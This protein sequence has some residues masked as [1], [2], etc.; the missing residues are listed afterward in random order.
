MWKL[1]VTAMLPAW[2]EKNPHCVFLKIFCIRVAQ[3]KTLNLGSF[4]RFEP[5]KD[6]H[7]R[8]SGG[9][10]VGQTPHRMLIN[11]SRVM[12]FPVRSSSSSSSSS[13]PSEGRIKDSGVGCL[14]QKVIA[15]SQRGPAC[16][17]I[18]YQRE[19]GN[20]GLRLSKCVACVKENVLW[21]MIES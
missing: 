7:I 17:H 6:E 8:T 16:L 3:K 11:P 14:S 15:G 5:D 2:L 13:S 4:S 9:Q 19:S 12:S 10:Q 18:R 1:G 20:C 21:T